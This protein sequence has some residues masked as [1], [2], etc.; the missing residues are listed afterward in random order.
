MEVTTPV[1]IAATVTDPGI[2]SVRVAGSRTGLHYLRTSPELHMKR[3]LAA[4][5]GSIFQIGPVFRAG[6]AGRYHHEE[7]TLLEWYRVDFSMEELI[8]EVGELLSAL[9]G[10]ERIESRRF[11]DV[12]QQYA[13]LDLMK[14]S[15]E[16]LREKVTAREPNLNIPAADRGALIDYVFAVEVAPHL[17]ADLPCVVRDYPAIHASLAKLDA[18]QPHLAR[19]FELFWKGLEL[20]NGFEE[21][22]DPKEQAARFDNDNDVRRLRG[23]DAIAMDENFIAALES[24]MPDCAGVAVGIDRFASPRA[25]I[26]RDQR[27]AYL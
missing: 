14:T 2:E 4:G 21:L 27:R 1:G 18:Q 11:D 5:S 15:T 7:F 13:A 16:E 20:A 23:L 24:G 26:Q 25:G 6:D 12:V 8:E 17:G 9:V 19:R 3:L 22:T 10:I